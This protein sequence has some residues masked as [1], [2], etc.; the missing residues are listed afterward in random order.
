MSQDENVLE[1]QSTS[2]SPER[3]LSG[4]ER[5]RTGIV[6]LADAL[7]MGIARHWLALINMAVAVYVLLPFLAPTFAAMGWIR[8]A[9]AIYGIYSFACH[10]LP[11]HSYFLFGEEPLYSLHALEASGLPAGL[12][13]LE[14]R[15]FIGE[16]TLGYK[17]AICQ[18]DVAIYGAVL[19]AGLVFALVRKR[20]GAPSLKLYALFLI[21]IALDG[22][23]QL[24]GFR[25]STW[26]LRTFT[27]ALFGAASVWLA[28]P[29]LEEAMSGVVADESDR[30]AQA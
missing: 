2:R 6:R 15:Y 5:T 14:R 9:Q 8:P 21:P 18:R 17:V 30:Q 10:Q 25:T 27:G 23:T 28:Y 22:L 16:E 1:N 13:V 24:L 19:L 7:V 3:S 11:D 26:W 4:S 12:N 20:I 29:Y